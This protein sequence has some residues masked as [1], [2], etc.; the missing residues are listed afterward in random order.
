MITQIK[1]IEEIKPIFIEYLDCISQFLEIKD[2]FAW[3]EVALKNL[4][5]YVVEAD[6]YV[7]IIRESESIVGF[8]L[9][10]KH[11]RFNNDGFAVAE[12]YI[13]KQYQG[14]G[15]GRKLAKYIFS[16]FLGNWEVAVSMQN[17]LGQEFWRQVLI[18]Y[19][20]GKFLEKKISSFNGIGFVFNN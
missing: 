17:N 13:Q 6:R 12:F 7:Y 14:Q 8:A 11:L 15:K 18:S 3:K 4:K 1:T 10:N 2:H 9:V 5:E 20:D 16:Q 19:T